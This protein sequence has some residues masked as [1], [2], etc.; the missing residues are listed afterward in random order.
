MYSHEIDQTLKKNNY[1][2]SSIDYDNIC[3]TSPQITRIKYDA[4]N[5][6]FYIK[7][8]DDYEF[9]FKVYYKSEEPN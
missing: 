7:T 1:N 6:N 5:D 4:Y 9:N 2:I 8:S 3:K